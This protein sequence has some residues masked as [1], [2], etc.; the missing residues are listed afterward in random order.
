M[1]VLGWGTER[2]SRMIPDGRSNGCKEKAFLQAFGV[3][4]NTLPVRFC[5]KFL[6]FTQ[7][8]RFEVKVKVV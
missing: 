5:F 6:F 7:K 3:S 8:Q 1:G 2:S 4:P